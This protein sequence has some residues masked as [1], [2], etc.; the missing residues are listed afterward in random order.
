[1]QRYIAHLIGLPADVMIQCGCT[2]VKVVRAEWLIARVG[3][4]A[5]IEDAEKRMR[6]RTCGKRPRLYPQGQW[7][8][9]G[10]R[11]LSVDPPA[12]PSWVDI[13]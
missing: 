7:Q 13:S 6:C 1:M 5:T 8:V 11:D 10:G 3:I 9:S 2:A 4:G 12:M